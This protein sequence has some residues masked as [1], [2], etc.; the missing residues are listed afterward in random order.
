MV[1]H[2]IK[3]SIYLRGN[4]IW[5]NRYFY[6]GVSNSFAWLMRVFI[7]NKRFSLPEILNF[8]NGEF[9]GSQVRK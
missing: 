8:I 1:H 6:A 2:H 5:W 7:A 9:V 4:F 3:R